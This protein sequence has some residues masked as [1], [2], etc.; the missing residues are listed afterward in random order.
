MVKLKKI[1]NL[2]WEIERQGI[3]K[4]DVRIFASEKLLENIKK[5]DTLK[6]AMN[7]T[8]LSGVLNP[9]IVL[10]DAHQGYGACIGGVSAMD[11][12]KGVISPGQIG[13][14]IN[15]GIRLLK[16][17]LEKKDLEGNKKLLDEIYSKIPSGLG[18]GSGFKLKLKEFNE[19][20]EKGVS[21]LVEKGYGSKKDL[22][23][24]EENGFI[25]G[26]NSEK[27]SKRAKQR[28]IGQLGTLGAGNHFVDVQVV[29][30]IFDK[31]FA[32]EF[33]LYE[34]QVVVMIH[35]G[36]RGFGHQ[37]ASDY[38]KL[39]ESEFGYE[40]LPDRQLINAPIKSSLGKDYFSAMACAA[41]F[42]FCNRHLIAYWIKEVFLK[43]FPDVKIET[44]Y[45]VAHNIA[46]IEE[47]LV[48]GKKKKV[49]VHRKGATR[50]FDGQPVLIPGSMGTSSYVLVG[51]KKAEELSFGSTAHGSGRVMSRMKA[52]KNIDIEKLKK[53]LKE[54]NI[55]IRASSNKSL[56]QESPEVYKNSSDV[57]EVV[58][59]LGIS[60]KVAKLKPLLVVMG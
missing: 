5:D 58:D 29:E 51:T 48:E 33:G 26:A 18:R 34:N 10:S 37:V 2:T 12:E 32:K 54:K 39:M 42:G 24:I 14:D 27:V 40:N 36:S 23:N 7:M 50:S 25:S 13:F 56:K 30:E 45:D 41:N 16:T 31:E 1:N 55:L 59:K 38:I 3:M 8:E 57:V 21:Y 28:G 44:L 49:C 17:N 60:K 53:D 6:Q 22:E 47:H 19:L 20:I 46:K 9:V 35:T 11:L 15:C 43:N 52:M 4:A